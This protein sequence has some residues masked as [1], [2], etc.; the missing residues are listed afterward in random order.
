MNPPIHHLSSIRYT[1][2]LVL[3]LSL[4]NLVSLPMVVAYN[5][6]RMQNFDSVIHFLLKCF[7]RLNQKITVCTI[8]I[9]FLNKFI[10]SKVL[11]T[12]GC[13][14]CFGL[15]GLVQSTWGFLGFSYALRLENRLLT[16][17]SKIRGL[18]YINKISSWVISFY[19]DSWRHC[20]GW[21]L[22]KLI[23]NRELCPVP[24]DIS[25]QGPTPEEKL[26]GD[27]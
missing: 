23:Y 18:P 1:L 19:Q 13:A 8:W 4:N 17:S 27:Y 7:T 15:L 6:Q 12:A 21:S 22:V 20:R 3:Y 26:F 2:S 24:T 16:T 10:I 5:N 25:I 11:A 14:C 9:R